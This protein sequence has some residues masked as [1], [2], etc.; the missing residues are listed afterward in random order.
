MPPA[1]PPEG[2]FVEIALEVRFACAMER[3]GEPPLQIG[4]H[5]MHPGQQDVCRHAA[6]RLAHVPVFPELQVARQTVADHSRVRRHHALNKAA[7][8]L[9]GAVPQRL[10]PHPPWVTVRGEFYRANDQQ[11]A[12][13]RDAITLDRVVLRAQRHFG[14][15]RLH[16]GLQ[17]AAVRRYHRPAQLV[18]QQPSRLVA[19]D[20]ELRLRLLGGNAVRMARQLVDRL[21]PRPQRQLAPMHDRTGRHRRLPVAAGTLPGEWLG[22]KL[23]ALADAAS[24]A[25]KTIRPPLR[26]EVAGA[27]RPVWK[28]S[29]ELRPRHW[30]I[31]FPSAH[32]KNIMATFGQLS[33][34]PKQAQLLPLGAPEPTGG[35]LKMEFAPTQG[36]NI[37]L[38]QYAPNKQIWIKGKQYTSKAIYSPYRDE[39][40]NAWTRRRL[41]FECSRCGHAKTEA[42]VQERQNLVIDCEACR[43]AGT[44]GPAKRWFRPPGFA[45]PIDRDPVTTADSPNETAY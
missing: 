26:G 39:R 24:G 3:A 28:P 43:S 33:T 30:P 10:Q 5:P 41:Y 4:E 20:A 16:H 23:P 18:Q 36:L 37:A 42:Y 17:Q 29:V 32:H 38:S 12:D 9:A 45:H 14:L 22:L 11:L 2:K 8:V 34:D 44:F 19:A 27:R 7:D 40:R 25:D 35:A 15:V 31:G 13:I 6:Y 21:E 1:V